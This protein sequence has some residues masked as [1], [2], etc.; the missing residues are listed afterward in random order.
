ME[1]RALL[2]AVFLMSM[3]GAGEAASTWYVKADAAA[4]GDGSRSRPFATLEQVE[5]ASKAGDIIRV[6]PSSRALDGGIQLKDGQRLIGLGDPVTR[7]AAGRALPTITNTSAT[8][9][10][11]DGVRLANNNLV[12]NIHVDGAARAGIFG[13][14]AARPTI[15]GTLITNNMIQG[16]DL[17]RLERLWPE[18]FVL[19]QSQG[20]HFWGITLLACGPG[21]SSY[22][23]MHAPERAAAP[24]FGE[25]VIAGNVIRDSNLEG[26]MLLTDTGAV[27]SFAITDTLVRD[28]S[29]KLP[30]PE[31]LTPPAGIVRSRAFTLIALNRSQV[32]LTLSRFHGENLSPAGNYA[33]DGLVFLT[34]GDSPVVNARISDAAILNPRM[35]GEVNNGDSIEIQHRGTTNGVLNIEM[36]RLELRDP[37][38]ANIKI[39]E[40]A[41]PTNGVYNLTV[42]DSVFSNTNPAGGLDGQIRLSGASNGT[43]AFTLK[44]RNTKFSGFGGAIGIL[45]ANNIDTLNVLVEN[46]SLSDF[47][48]PTGATPIAA[49]TVTHPA[50]KKI[51]TAVID[52]GGGPLGSRGRN[53]FVKNAGFDLSVS[54]ANAGTAPIRVDAAGNYWGGGAPA[55][56]AA[57]QGA[58]K[59]TDGATDIAISGNVMFNPP[60]HLTS[61]PA[62]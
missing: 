34:G 20:N 4:G 3:A 48:A 37:A 51:G 47:T 22:C 60:T 46:S 13:V 55:T 8:R 54:N 9:Y 26:I 40:A 21:G 50:D 32:N 5:T 23:A 56:G 1:R 57:A 44:V 19:Y 7:A 14:N 62:R 45:N 27:G 53:R 58:A 59:A 15:R 39:L 38:S 43:K 52:L 35:V 61:D 41:N 29:L 28:L 10:N 25:A 11:G 16:N 49:V 36:T 12:E 17:R 31:S 24:N 2:A 6:E 42:S 33:T 30:R 18:G